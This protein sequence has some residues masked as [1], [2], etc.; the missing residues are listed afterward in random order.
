MCFFVERRVLG[1]LAFEK[2]FFRLFYQGHK[3]IYY[4]HSVYYRGLDLRPSRNLVSTLRSRRFFAPSSASF[5]FL[6]NSLQSRR[7][8]TRRGTRR[9]TTSFLSP[10]YRESSTGPSLVEIPFLPFALSTLRL[11]A[12]IRDEEISFLLRKVSSCAY[13]PRRNSIE[14]NS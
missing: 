3:S 1:K 7:R 2:N 14:S 10:K 5:F 11:F 6:R 4:T 9:D 12:L 13:I 8:G